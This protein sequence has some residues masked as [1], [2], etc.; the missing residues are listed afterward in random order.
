M[1]ILKDIMEKKGME[2]PPE[3]VVYVLCSEWGEYSDYFMTV[4]EVFVD[5]SEANKLASEYNSYC[6]AALNWLRARRPS[7]ADKEE[8]KLCMSMFNAVNPRPVLMGE[9]EYNNFNY[10][11]T[12][13]Y[14]VHE[15]KIR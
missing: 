13:A 14:S 6:R 12:G 15:V 11:H 4:Q 3:P 8:L 1:K 2:I 9:E 5:E 10:W 7:P